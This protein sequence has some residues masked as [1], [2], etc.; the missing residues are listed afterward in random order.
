MPIYLYHRFQTAATAKLIGGA[1]F[2]YGEVAGPAVI[3][4]PE[5][6]RAALNAVLETLDPKAL[7]LS[8]EVLSHL[9]PRL[10]SWSFADNDR[11]LFRKTAHPAFD[12]V[13]AAETA[14]DLTFDVLLHPQRAARLVEFHRRDAKNPSLDYVLGQTAERVMS[15]SKRGRTAEIGYAVQARF[16]FALMEL[17][18]GDSGPAVKAAAASALNYM[19]TRSGAGSDANNAWLVDR[20]RAFRTRPVTAS[21][22]TS[23]AKAIPPGSPIG[24]E[25]G[26]SE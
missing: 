5:R 19:A 13:S 9:T 20:I 11:E 14:A 3:V 24:S 26:G 22:S 4:S 6:Q 25:M 12:T 17:A 7:D 16:A 2:T 8:D 10:G 23:P 18:E 1:S 15:A 21:A